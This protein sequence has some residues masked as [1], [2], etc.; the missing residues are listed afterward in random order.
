MNGADCDEMLNE[1]CGIV[2]ANCERGLR[3]ET[4]FQYGSIAIIATL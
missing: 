1:K 3:N 4:A 2:I